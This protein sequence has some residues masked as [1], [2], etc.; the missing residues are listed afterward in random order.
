MHK[1]MHVHKGVRKGFGIKP[2][3]LNLI[4]YK[5][6]VTCAKDINCFPIIFACYFVTSC[7]YHEINLH[8]N[9]KEHCKWAKK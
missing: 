3:P 1:K 9:L 6:F 4:F 8:A 2:P 7:K 5:N